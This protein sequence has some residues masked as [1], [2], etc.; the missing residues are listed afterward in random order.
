MGMQV[1]RSLALVFLLLASGCASI[2]G[3][4][5]SP[6][7]AKRNLRGGIAEFRI[8][9]YDGHNLTGRVFVGATIDPLLFDGRLVDGTGVKLEKVRVCGTTKLLTYWVADLPSPPEAD[10]I[11]TLRPGYWHGANEKFFLFDEYTDPG[12]DCFEANLVVRVLDGRVAATLPIRVVRT[13][14]PAPPEGGTGD[15]GTGD[16][17]TG[18]PMRTPSDAGAP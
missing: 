2:P 11:I 15:G 5:G 4:R 9:S 6:K 10:E 17:G 14:K 3:D 7:V 13:D 12:P 18:E 16:G 1:T 8:T